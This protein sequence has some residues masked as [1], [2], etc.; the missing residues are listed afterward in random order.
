MVE[1][2]ATLLVSEARKRSDRELD[3]HAGKQR[4]AQD[5]ASRS[6]L[7]RKN[8]VTQRITQTI[9]IGNPAECFDGGNRM[10]DITITYPTEDEVLAQ[11]YKD[12][13][14]ATQSESKNGVDYTHGEEVWKAARHYTIEVQQPP[15]NISPNLEA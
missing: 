2:Y 7:S 6:K 14:D 15:P 12:W 4:F 13:W 3:T 5:R 1:L 10:A 9:H 8:K 11:G